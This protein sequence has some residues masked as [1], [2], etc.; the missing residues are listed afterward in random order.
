MNKFL[1]FLLVLLALAAVGCGGANDNGGAPAG[2]PD[3]SAVLNDAAGWL[4]ANHQNSDGGYTGFSNGANQAPSDPIG[5][6]DAI[7]ALSAAGNTAAAEAPLNYLRDNADELADFAAVSGGAAGKT[8]LALNAAG[9]NPRDFGG[10]DFVAILT[11]QLESDGRYNGQTPFEQSLALLGLAAANE[12]ADDQAL[13]WLKN[14]QTDSGAWGDGY[15]TDEN[16]DATGMAVMALVAHSEPVDG[17]ALS[18]AKSWLVATQLSDGSWEYADGYGSN[19][20]STALVM[21]GLSA[22]GEN[23]YGPGSGWSK[24]GRTPLMAL[25]SYRSASGAF[26]ADFGSGPFD[27]FYTT[28]QVMPALTGKPYPLT[29]G[30]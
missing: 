21:Q 27:N 9:Q 24:S 12:R 14:Q 16:A 1:S 23:F 20:S 5:S 22:L 29:S 17:D 10:H 15:G 13:Q 6:L 8:I 3:Q 28:I 18:R 11:G 25:V 26:Q 4:V 7:I 2:F 19:A 30:R